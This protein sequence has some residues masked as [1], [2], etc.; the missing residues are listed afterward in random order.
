MGGLGPW[1]GGVAFR[2]VQE[3]RKPARTTNMDNDLAERLLPLQEG[4]V[5]FICPVVCT[6]IVFVT[7]L[8]GAGLE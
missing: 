6:M 8:G 3:A 5:W 4:K 7:K 2:F 1:I